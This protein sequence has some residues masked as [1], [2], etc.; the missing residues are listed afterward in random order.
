MRR[1]VKWCVTVNLGTSQG[2]CQIGAV[3][4]LTVMMLTLA[5]IILLY[6]Y[7]SESALYFLLVSFAKAVDA[8]EQSSGST[9]YKIAKEPPLAVS[10]TVRFFPDLFPRRQDV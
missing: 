2:T 7:L 6:F 1:I 10:K 8:T 5:K 4:P 3:L 9:N